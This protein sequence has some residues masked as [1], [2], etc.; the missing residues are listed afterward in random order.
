M[1][2]CDKINSGNDEKNI[3]AGGRGCNA[4]VPLSLSKYARKLFLYFK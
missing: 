1:S 3:G 2:Y 4:V